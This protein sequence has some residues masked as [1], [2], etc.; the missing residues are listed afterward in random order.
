MIDLTRILTNFFSL[1]TPCPINDKKTLLEGPEFE[2][3]MQDVRDNNYIFRNFYDKVTIGDQEVQYKGYWTADR[4]CIIG[5][6]EI[7]FVDGSVYMG[8]LKDQQFNGKGR[9]SRANGDIY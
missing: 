9:L 1:D 7:K 2:A 6:G 3:I 5:L 4:S 8:Q